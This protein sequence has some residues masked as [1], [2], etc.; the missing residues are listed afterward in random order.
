MTSP[1][2]DELDNALTNF[3]NLYQLIDD[4]KGDFADIIIPNIKNMLEADQSDPGQGLV[5]E[6][7]S[8]FMGSLWA[9]SGFV[10]EPY[11]AFLWGDYWNR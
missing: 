11:G 7:L 1:T 5:G 3:A 6:I 9:L 2:T 10:A 8:G 4:L